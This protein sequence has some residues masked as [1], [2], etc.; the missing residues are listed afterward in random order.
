MTLP[1]IEH[2]YHSPLMDSARWQHFVPRDS[3]IIVSTPYK[4]GTTWTQWICALLIFGQDGLR[5]PLS[6]ISPWLDQNLYPIEAVAARYAAQ[7]HRRIIKTHTPLTAL[8]YYPDVTY[9]VCARDPRDVFISMQNHYANLDMAKFQALLA[10]NT[11]I[12]ITPPVV[13]DDI[14]ARFR[15]WLAQG[16]FPWETDGYPFWSVFHHVQS[17]WRFRELPNIHVMHYADLKRDLAGQMQRIARTLGITVGG[18]QWAGLVAAAGF[19]AMQ[20][21]YADI[22][23]NI[24]QQIWIDGAKFFNKGANGQWREVLDRAS[25]HAYEQHKRARLEPSLAEWIDHV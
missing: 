7:T 2:R 4:S 23:P 13:P 14:N 1:T 5:E 15:L 19:D 25:L 20:A 17:F 6:H 3:D 18:A 24:D 22:A 9:L 12:A 10:R 21:R 11:D 16:S 8:P